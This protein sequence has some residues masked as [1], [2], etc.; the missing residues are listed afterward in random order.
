MKKILKIIFFIIVCLS[1]TAAFWVSKDLLF[2]FVTTKAFFF[3]ISVELAL[4]FYLYFLVAEPSLRP[5]LKNFLN[6]SVLAFVAINFAASFAGVNVNHSLWGNFE[7]MGGAYYIAHLTALYFY[8][9]MLGQMQG[10]YLQWFLKFL[11][12]MGIAVAVNG[13]FG[14]L[15]LPTVVQ[16]PS[17]PGRVS[18]TLGNPIYLGS[19]LII[20]LFLAL[21]FAYSAEGWFRKAGYYILG[22]I[23]LLGILLSG[24]RGAVIGLLAGGFISVIIYLFFSPSKKIRF[25]GFIGVAVLIAVS[26]VMFVY[27][28]KLPAGSTLQRIFKLKDSNTEARLIQWKTALD[29]FKDHP[30]LGVGPENYYI[31]ANFYYHPEIFQYDKSWFDK[32]HNYILEILVTDGIVGLIAYLSMLL[33][34]VVALYKGYKSELFSGAEMSFLLAA[35][36]AYQIQNL[37]VFDTVPASLMFFSFLGFAGYML[38]VSK[39]APKAQKAQTK[40]ASLPAFSAAVFGIGALVAGYAIYATNIIPMAIAKDVNYGYAY[41]GVDPTKSVDYFNK[42]L[43]LP[44]NFDPAETGS[45]YSDFATGFIRSSNDQNRD[46]ALQTLNSSIAY[47]ENCL[48]AQPDNPI[49]WQRVATSYLFKAVQV[50]NQVQVDPRAEQDIEKAIALAPK[51][52]DAYLSQ[53]QILGVEGKVSDAQTLLEKLVNEFPTDP[54]AKAQLATVYRVEGS[55]GKAVPLMEAAEKQ[56]YTFSAYADMK[57]MID[58]YVSQKDFT[59]ALDLQMQA[60]KVEPNNLQVFMDL[61]KL[62]AA[63]GYPQQ[64]ATLAQEIINYDATK[65]AEMQALIDSLPKTA[66]T[67]Q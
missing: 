34:V 31:I 46:L 67:T 5:S 55:V 35:L 54:G 63:A 52:E 2:P 49:L 22:F 39:N 1:V 24:T 7:R 59:K 64:A 66:T 37:F 29:G 48:A 25:Y 50:G 6:V 16:D 32:P 3:R 56:G 57:W 42:A 62:Y 26:S 40:N 65:K 58:Y 36:L 47:M 19:Y 28:D 53:A 13:I 20:P 18:S 43:T 4:P 14:W 27:N 10:K 23:S 45:K 17:L 33:F 9:L 41:A 44:F 15:H 38:S 30:V 21:F 51:R 61:A 60:E 12:W 11:L 8:V